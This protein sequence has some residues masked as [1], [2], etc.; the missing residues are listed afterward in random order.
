M[1]AFKSKPM[2][3]KIKCLKMLIPPQM[4]YLVTEMNK[5]LQ[6]N[7]RIKLRFNRMK[8]RYTR[9]QMNRPNQTQQSKLQTKKQIPN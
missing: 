1:L 7:R 5:K 6:T 4:D 8:V 2:A 9:M 3:L